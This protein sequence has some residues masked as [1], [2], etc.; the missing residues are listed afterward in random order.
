MPAITEM[1]PVLIMKLKQWID[2]GFSCSQESVYRTKQSQIYS[3]ID[4]YVGSEH[5]IHFKYSHILDVTFVTM[6]YGLG[7]PILFPIAAVSYLV[8]WAVE[9]YQVAYTYPLPPAL[10]DKLTENALNMLS[11]SPFLLLANGYWMLSNR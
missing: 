2:R 10:D 7:M 3:Y 8:F 6:M 5:Q 4:L 11:L 1:I 9:R